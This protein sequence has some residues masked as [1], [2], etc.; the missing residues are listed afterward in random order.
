MWL[1]DDRAFSMAWLSWFTAHLIGMVVVATLTV[2][3]LRE[4]RGLFGRPGRRRRFVAPLLTLAVVSI[5]V[6]WQDHYPLL[7]LVFPPLLWLTFRHRFSG[8]VVG[9]LLIALIA[10]SASVAGHGPLS[11]LPGLSSVERTLLLQ[12]RARLLPFQTRAD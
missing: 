6:F 9:V 1:F 3:G 12:F 10:G 5:G 2:V 7:F 4:G 11:M 8:V